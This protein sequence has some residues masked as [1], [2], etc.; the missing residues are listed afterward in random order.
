MLDVLVVVRFFAAAVLVDFLAATFAVL[1]PDFAVVLL[2]VLTGVFEAWLLVL[3]AAVFA[4]GCAEDVDFVGAI[5]SIRGAGF[6]AGAAARTC[7]TALVCSSRVL[8]NSW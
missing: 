1:L 4:A 2:A 7:L 3:L 8:R 6:F 5:A